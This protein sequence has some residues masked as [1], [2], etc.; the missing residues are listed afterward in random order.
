MIRMM[1]ISVPTPR[2]IR[3]SSNPY[4]VVPLTTACPVS[5]NIRVNGMR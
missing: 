4:L 5:T 1:A 2:Y 3:P